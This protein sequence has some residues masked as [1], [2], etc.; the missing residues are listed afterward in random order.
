[1]FFSVIEVSYT[2]NYYTSGVKP[3]ILVDTVLLQWETHVNTTLVT[4]TR[5]NFVDIYS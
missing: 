3:P 5:Q 4:E 2:I 1:M